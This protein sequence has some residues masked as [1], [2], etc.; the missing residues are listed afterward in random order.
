MANDNKASYFCI[1]LTVMLGMVAIAAVLIYIGGLR[2]R[3]NEIMIETYYERAVAGLSVGSPVNVRGVPI[4]EVREISF[5]GNKYDVEGVTNGCIYILLAVNL[6]KILPEHADIEEFRQNFPSIMRRSGLRA[7]VSANGITGLSKVELDY[8]P[9]E[10]RPP[11]PTWT[12]LHVYVPSKVSLLDNFSV[13][14]TKVM[15]QI[16]RMDLNA[17][18]SNLNASVESLSALTLSSQ[19]LLEGY[20]PEVERMV[21]NLEATSSSLKEF[22]ETIRQN[23]SILLRGTDQDPLPETRP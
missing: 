5:I 6:Q 9:D 7:T 10:P 22:S 8:Y 17:F 14:A 19:H 16:N 13:S 21:Q 2:G 12:P 18:W 23:P 20:Q 1:G 11:D 3:E 15:N 4:G